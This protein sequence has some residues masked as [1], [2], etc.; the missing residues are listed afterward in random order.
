MTNRLQLNLRLDGRR[1]L[2]ELCK[3]V[4]A[5]QGLSLNAWVIKQLEL[6]VTAPAKVPTPTTTRQ[7]LDTAIDTTRQPLDTVRDTT[8]QTLDRIAEPLDKV[9]DIE[10]VTELPGKHHLNESEVE[11]LRQEL[12]EVKADR[13]KLL[14]SSTHITN[15]L[16]QEAHELRSQLETERADLKQN[17]TTAS[18][19]PEPEHIEFLKRL[20]AKKDPL[21]SSDL[22]QEIE[23]LNESHRRL[24][25]KM[26]AER[27]ESIEKIS[28]LEDWV[29]GLT[30]R[31]E[32]KQ[33]R[34]DEL[35]AQLEQER[36]D[37]EKI[38]AGLAEQKQKLAPASELPEAADLLNQLK[39]K[40]KK[41]TVS[42]ADV[43]TLLEIIEKFCD[44]T[45]AGL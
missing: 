8:R 39:A 36:A 20:V 43:E 35:E 34:L 4:A 11:S 42:L 31:I 30:R 18:E 45:L 23:R 33:A 5:T 15:K 2:L 16:C 40:R 3:E 22:W 29:K 32:E 17:L 12:E 6:G 21:I 38:E 37:R 44:D 10:E 14:E 9:L 26:G 19:L 7:P 25:L 13:A 1:D 41:S 28:D 24:R 27:R